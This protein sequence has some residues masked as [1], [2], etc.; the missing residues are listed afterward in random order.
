MGALR[1]ATPPHARVPLTRCHSRP[2]SNDTQID[3]ASLH[4]SRHDTVQA[5]ATWRGRAPAVL[6]TLR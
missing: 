3:Q 4:D 1:G 2:E 5:R 6:S